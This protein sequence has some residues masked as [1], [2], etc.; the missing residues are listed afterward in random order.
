LD[1]AV[2]VEASAVSLIKEGRFKAIAVTGPQR[3][4]ALPDFPTLGEED[5]LESLKSIG[6]YAIYGLLGPAGMP[7]SVIQA[8]SNAIARVVR[9]PDVIERFDRSYVRGKTSTPDEFRSYLDAEVNKW[10]RLG[11]ELNVTFD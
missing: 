10:K 8:L 4:A 2:Q 5:G 11:K 1:F 3:L 7:P 6:V 9:M